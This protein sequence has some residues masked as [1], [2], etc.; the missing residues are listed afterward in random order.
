MNQTAKFH[1]PTFDRSEVNLS[2]WQTNW[3][4]NRQTGKQTPLETS[5]SLHCASR[6]V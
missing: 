5:T 3:Q 6:R 2:C 1:Y 4:T